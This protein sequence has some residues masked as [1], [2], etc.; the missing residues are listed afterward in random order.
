[1]KRKPAKEIRGVF[2]T[3]HALSKGGLFSDSVVQETDGSEIY[4]RIHVIL[5]SSIRRK[6][7]EKANECDAYRPECEIDKKHM[8]HVSILKPLPKDHRRKIHRI[9]KRAL[10]RCRPVVLSIR[11]NT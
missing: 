9:L 4:N 7:C 11:E 10:M 6:A 8:L 1:M 3:S 5:C 2:Y